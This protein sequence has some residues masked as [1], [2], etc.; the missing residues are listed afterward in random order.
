[1]LYKSL[2]M[3]YLSGKQEIF[4]KLC[5]GACENSAASITLRESCLLIGVAYYVMG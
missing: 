2:I 3:N 1:M 5:R 4:L